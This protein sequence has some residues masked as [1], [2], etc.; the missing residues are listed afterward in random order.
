MSNFNVSFEQNRGFQS[1]IHS[2]RQI[3]NLKKNRI[4]NK[5][6]LSPIVVQDRAI[7]VDRPK[8]KISKDFLR[9]TMADPSL[10]WLRISTA[11][12][13]NEQREAKRRERAERKK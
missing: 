2:S 1:V 7:A 8:M 3:V 5:T 13:V 12:T 4:S 6:T 11:D 9:Q 10:E